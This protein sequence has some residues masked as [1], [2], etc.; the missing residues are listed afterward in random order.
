MFTPEQYRAKAAQYD[1]LLKTAGTPA[2]E[3]EYR[4]LKQSYG[5][6]AE[7]LDWLAANSAKTVGSGKHPSLRER[8]ERDDAHA[9]QE[10]VLR[11][12]GAV[13]L[14]DAVVFWPRLP[15]ASARPKPTAMT[16]AGMTA[17]LTH[18]I[19]FSSE[20]IST[21]SCRRIFF[22]S[23]FAWASFWRK[24]ASSC[25]CSGERMK[26]WPPSAFA[27]CSSF[28]RRWVSARLFSS[29]WILLR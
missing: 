7:N 5:S 27:R 8:A 12:L 22:S 23:I 16:S 21:R 3:A 11:C 15:R 19:R 20:S 17:M 24:L 28:T 26:R 2:E 9:E 4:D 25:C 10:N 6:L 29:S 1:A 18:L 14:V 13:A